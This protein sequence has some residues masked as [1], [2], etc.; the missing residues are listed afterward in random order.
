MMVV[1]VMLGYIYIYV[2]MMMMMMMMFL[3]M[4]TMTFNIRG[5]L[6]KPGS[7]AK[8]KALGPGPQALFVY[9]T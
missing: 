3:W 1:V 4:M 5:L 7:I 6:L 2:M 9:T 8:C